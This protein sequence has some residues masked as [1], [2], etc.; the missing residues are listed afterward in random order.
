MILPDPIDASPGMVREV[1][2]TLVATMTRRWPGGAGLKTSACPA[3]GSMANS[4]RT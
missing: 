3:A 2:A 4:G 1:S